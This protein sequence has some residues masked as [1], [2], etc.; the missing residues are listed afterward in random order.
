MA[1]NQFNTLST[2][3]KIA[4]LFPIQ[5]KTR[6]TSDGIVEI[7]IPDKENIEN[8]I[9]ITGSNTYCLDISNQNIFE[10]HN[11]D[12]NNMT[13]QYNGIR[14][15]VNGKITYC[16]DQDTTQFRTQLYIYH[17]DGDGYYYNDYITDEIELFS[18]YYKDPAYLEN[19]NNWYIQ[20]LNGIVNGYS[21]EALYLN[22]SIE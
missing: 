15:Y 9:F 7:Y 16:T 8:P 5:V 22:I 20:Y 1:T 11:Y 18:Q 21:D 10:I 4:E 3:K 13:C 19:T 14:K 17:Y 12:S 2:K 6:K